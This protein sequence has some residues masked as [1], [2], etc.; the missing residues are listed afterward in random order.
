MGEGEGPCRRAPD[1]AKARDATG[2]RAA[3]SYWQPAPRVGTNGRRHCRAHPTSSFPP[4]L[5]P[6]SS[7][8][9]PS[10]PAPP[11]FFMGGS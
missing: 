3:V 1:G 10:P 2:R 9:A 11:P 4:P 5:H 6:P 8:L 7:S